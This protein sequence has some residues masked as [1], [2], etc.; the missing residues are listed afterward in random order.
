MGKTKEKKES[1][2]T[3]FKRNRDISIYYP[4][5]TE[6]YNSS[7]MQAKTFVKQIKTTTKHPKRLL[8]LT[9]KRNITLKHVSANDL[10]YYLHFKWLAYEHI[11]SHNQEQL[12]EFFQALVKYAVSRVMET[13]PGI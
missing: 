13:A 5:I 2:I 8:I 10:K 4:C 12:L 1:E 3:D 9:Y 6:I 11:F 7:N